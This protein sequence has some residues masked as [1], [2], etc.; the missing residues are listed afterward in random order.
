VPA[1]QDAGKKKDK[2]IIGLAD[3]SDED[4][5]MHRNLQ[6]IKGAGDWLPQ[7]R[8][9]DQVGEVSKAAGRTFQWPTYQDLEGMDLRKRI[10]LSGFGIKANT[11]LYQLKF[12]YTGSYESRTFN[13]MDGTT[14]DPKLHQVWPEKPIGSV[15]VLVRSESGQSNIYGIRFMDHRDRQ[16]Q[17]R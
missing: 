14:D 12:V 17:E 9:T 1:E 16:I 15:E 13:S 3:D 11:N 2:N 10:K 8:K 5:M 7:L 4:D 6:P